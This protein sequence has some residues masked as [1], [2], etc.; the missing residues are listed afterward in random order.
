MNMYFKNIS[1]AALA[2]M[3]FIL[4]LVGS[5]Q[6]GIPCNGADCGF[7]DLIVLANNIVK[8]IVFQVSV[9]LAAL[10]FMVVGARLVLNQD[11][12]GAWSEAKQS[13]EMIAK[14]FAIILAAFLLV[15]FVLSAFL[16][17]GFTNFLFQ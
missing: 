7:N 8:F 5:A 12:D 15:K 14:G 16:S 6:I 13:F 2:G 10:G 9:P 17:T 4:P 1:L 3:A 11:K